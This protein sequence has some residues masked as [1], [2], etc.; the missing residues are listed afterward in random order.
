MVAAAA[1]CKGT[2]AD[3]FYIFPSQYHRFPS[4]IELRKVLKLFTFC[5]F[6][7]DMWQ[8]NF[9]RL[10]SKKLGPCV[11]EWSDLICI[12]VPCKTWC[13]DVGLYRCWY[14]VV[15]VGQDMW[16]KGKAVD[17]FLDAWTQRFFSLLSNSDTKS[18]SQYLHACFSLRMLTGHFLISVSF[19]EA[20]YHSLIP[21][22]VSQGTCFTLKDQPLLSV[23]PV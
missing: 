10:P 3:S 11:L 17:D 12:A 21:V 4:L 20:N 6:Y 15:M 22:Y 14:W 18:K 16:Q 8:R 5:I 13:P 1:A 23:T 7:R 9:H 2:K 19:Y